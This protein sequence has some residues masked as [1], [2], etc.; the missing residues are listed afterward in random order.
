MNINRN[1][2]EEYFLLYADKELSE[3]EKSMVEMF[4]Q[5]NPD[6]EEEFVTLQQSVVKPDNTITLEDKSS[7]FRN[8]FINQDNYEEKFLLYADNELNLSEIAETEKFVLSNPSLQNDFILLQKVKYEPDTAIVF[9]DK[10]LLYKKEKNGKVIPFRWKALA[11]AVLLGVGLWT[12]VTYLQKDKTEPV[13]V[14]G[15]D[16]KV[17]TIPVKPVEEKQDDK[18]VAKAVESK[19]QPLQIIEQKK[20]D[21]P[22]NQQPQDVAVKNIQPVTVIK[23]QELPK[24]PEPKKEDVAIN[25]QPLKT[26]IPISNNLEKPADPS[27]VIDKPAAPVVRTN[28]DAHYASYIADAEVKNENYVFYNITAEEFRKSKIGNFLKKA[29]RVIENKIPFRGKGLKIG[30]VEIT[31]DE[32]N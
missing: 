15:P 4:V 20:L 25:Q 13:I 6:L 21:K 32:Q 26:E 12:G 30:N 3:D 1:N 17:K 19:K 5:Q 18:N 9:P 31:K 11:A 16:V 14:K 7:L 24:L 2:Y 8:E 29:K 27:R 23:Q 10:G 28:N 22:V